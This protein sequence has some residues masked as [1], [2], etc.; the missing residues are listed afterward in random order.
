MLTLAHFYATALALEPLFPDLGSSFCSAMA[1][2]PLE[3]IISVTNAMQS[4]HVHDTSSMEIASLMQY[5]QQ[6]ALSYRNRAIQYTQLGAQPENTMAAISPKTL[7]YTSIGILSPALTPSTPAYSTS[8]PPSSVSTPFLEVPGSQPSFTF[9]TQTWG[10]MPSPGF[11]PQVYTSQEGHIY[12]ACGGISL[13][14]FSGG[15]VPTAPIWT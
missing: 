5:P 13:S 15:F 9:G 7:N 11:P 3:A 10:A 6:T 12:D 4:R 1:L 14:N 8:Q 2:P